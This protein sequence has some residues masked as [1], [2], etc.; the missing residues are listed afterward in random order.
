MARAPSSAVSDTSGE[1]SGA[2]RASAAW[3]TA[4]MPLVTERGTGR[5][6]VSSGS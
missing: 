4:L 3:A 5:E 2:Y 1:A 6:R